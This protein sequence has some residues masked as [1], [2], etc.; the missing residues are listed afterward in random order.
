[1]EVSV[2]EIMRISR[3]RQAINKLEFR[4][5]VWTYQGKPL[6]IPSQLLDDFEICGLNNIDFITSNFLPDRPW[7]D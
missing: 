6:D 4:N 7:Q 3:E 5:I 1:M 2:E